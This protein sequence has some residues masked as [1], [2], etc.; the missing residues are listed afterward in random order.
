V[1]QSRGL[2]ARR[3]S[4]VHSGP[5]TEERPELRLIGTVVHGSSP[6]WHDEQEE[7]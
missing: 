2:V 7:D 5:W 6:W 4:I 1:H 3:Q